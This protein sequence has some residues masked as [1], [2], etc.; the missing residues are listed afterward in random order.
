MKKIWEMGVD[1]TICVIAAPTSRAD[2][3]SVKWYRGHLLLVLTDFGLY[4]I[5]RAK[6][7]RI[8]EFPYNAI[9]ECAFSNN[10]SELGLFLI[11]WCNR[12]FIS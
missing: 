4:Y 9:E 7:E 2:Q 6:K 3:V 10:P 12:G 8:A 1:G 5:W 11:P